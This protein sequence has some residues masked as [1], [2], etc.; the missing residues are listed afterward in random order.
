MTVL[1][2][3]NAV[4]HSFQFLWSTELLDVT[5]QPLGDDDGSDGYS[6]QSKQEDAQQSGKMNLFPTTIALSLRMNVP[7]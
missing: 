1:E 2:A 3:M 5:R 7:F 6:P 4:P